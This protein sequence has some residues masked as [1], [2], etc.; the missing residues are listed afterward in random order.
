MRIVGARPHQVRVPG[1]LA[2]WEADG[3]ATFQAEPFTVGVSDG[4]LADLR[5]RIQRTRWP[6]AAPGVL[7]EQGTDLGY[8]RELLAYWA[9]GFDWRAQERWLN[10]FRHFR[11]EI[12]GI[13]STSFTSGLAAAVGFR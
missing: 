3:V 4:V 7:W 13:G 1:V 5:A 8:L 12:D 6:A 2:P 10:G 9:G 11:V